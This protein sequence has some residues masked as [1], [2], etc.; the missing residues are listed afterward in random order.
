MLN[1]KRRLIV[2]GAIT[3]VLLLVVLLVPLST[4]FAACDDGN[5]GDNNTSCPDDGVDDADDGDSPSPNAFAEG[6]DDIVEVNEDTSV[7]TGDGNDEEPDRL[8]SEEDSSADSDPGVPGSDDITIGED[9]EVDVVAGDAVR[10][11]DGQPDEIVVEGDADFVLGDGVIDGN[12]ADAGDD[13]DPVAG[14]APDGDGVDEEQV[15][16]EIIIEGQAGAVLGDGIVGGDGGPD[17]ITVTSDDDDDDDEDGPDVIVV[18][19]DGVINGNGGNDDIQIG[20]DVIIIAGDGI[21]NGIP[22]GDGSTP[23]RRDLADPAN[24]E[25]VE[26][27]ARALEVALNLPADQSPIPIP[28]EYVDTVSDIQRALEYIGSSR[29]NNGGV[30]NVEGGDDNIVVE[31]GAFGGA[32]FGDGILD[33]EGEAIGGADEIIVEEDAFVGAVFGD[34][35]IGAGDEQEAVDV[36]SI[37]GFT[38][39]VAGDGT[40]FGNG[41]PDEIEILETSTSYVVLGDGVIAGDGAPDTI[42]VDGQTW[43]VAGDAVLGGNGGDDTITVNGE[44]Y[45]LIGDGATNFG[46]FDDDEP[47]TV[48]GADEI[49]VGAEGTAFVVLGDGVVGGDGDVDAIFI[50]G[51]NY[52]LLG[53]GTA[54]GDGADDYIEINGVSYVVIGDGVF[55]GASGNDEIVVTEDGFAPV[56]I[57]DGTFSGRGLTELLENL[58]G[59]GGDEAEVGLTSV[60]P[61]F[62][63][64]PPEDAGAPGDDVIDLDGETYLVIAD[65]VLDFGFEELAAIDEEVIPTDEG[66]GMD[67]VFVNLETISG[68][69]LLTD[70]ELILLFGD[71]AQF[72]GFDDDDGFANSAVFANP[73][74]GDVLHLEYDGADKAEVKAQLEEALEDFYAEVDED[75]DGNANGIR[76]GQKFTIIELDGKT[77]AFAEFDDVRI[78]IFFGSQTDIGEKEEEPCEIY[79]DDNVT[80]CASE[81]GIE[82]WD[83]NI[84]EG[85][86]GIGFIPYS[87]IDDGKS[88]LLE[89]VVYNDG[90]LELTVTLTETGLNVVVTGTGLPATE[91]G[92]TGPTLTNEIV[93]V[94]AP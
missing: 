47:E 9:V 92:G 88:P 23:R 11:L 80:V 87:D 67:D 14:D 26:D 7:V 78:L 84:Q 24:W 46:F 39:L 64:G 10:G 60:N 57:G 61:L 82:F 45:V 53:D 42:V 71:D 69:N 3:T 13:V 94:T 74:T 65:G 18:N 59:G 6:G 52:V 37:A 79:R 44:T 29:V 34:G 49:R 31:E 40:L 36:I 19:G 48:G 90:L 30:E 8:L 12:G 89:G 83:P 55:G 5:G 21:V 68:T 1:S 4:V 63:F 66:P 41:G 25:D 91:E 54:F 33:L 62:D 22:T 70:N 93:P 73:R 50:D 85:F 43:V 77:I 38:F 20:G 15:G 32:V 86:A 35:I 75:A 76:A 27:V 51:E 72:I 28:P 17:T 58:L 2:G 16:D 81:D 56:I